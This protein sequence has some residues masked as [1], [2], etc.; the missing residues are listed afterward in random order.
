MTMHAFTI[1]GAPE[2]V[3]EIR[4]KLLAGGCQVSQPVPSKSI[5][6]ALDA[7]I[8]ADELRMV[9]EIITVASTA[10]VGIVTAI[11]NAVQKYEQ[12]TV[13]VGDAKTGAQL[14]EAN[15]DTNEESLRRSLENRR[16]AHP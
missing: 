9:M 4:E 2:V 16:G 11:V 15:R 5:A 6:D 7:P 3:K 12:A 14:A 1:T 10:T 8:G 13:K